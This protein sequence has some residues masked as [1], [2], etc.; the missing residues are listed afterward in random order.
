MPDHTNADLRKA[1]QAAHFALVEAA[2]HIRSHEGQSSAYRRAS[3]AS[4]AA[5]EA[6]F[7]HHNANA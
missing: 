2:D 5:R 1:L 4:D 3:I 6:L 7:S